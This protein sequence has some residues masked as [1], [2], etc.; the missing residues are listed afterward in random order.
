MKKL[1]ALL[2]AGTMLLAMAACGNSSAGSSQPPAA[3]PTQDAAT[4]TDPPAEPTDPPAETD[5]PAEPTDAPAAP[6]NA[7][8]APGD[9]VRDLTAFYNTMFPE[10]VASG[11]TLVPME[12]DML[13]YAYPGLAAMDLKQMVVYGPLMSAVAYEIALVEAPDAATAREVKA[14]LDSR[15]SNMQ[16]DQGN[17]PAVTEMWQTSAYAE[18]DG[19]YLMLVVG[20]NAQEEVN[21]FH[22]YIENASIREP[23]V[24][25][26]AGGE[27]V[28]NSFGG[29]EGD[30][31]EAGGGV[32]PPIFMPGGPGTPGVGG[33]VAG[34]PDEEVVPVEP[35]PEG[36]ADLEGFFDAV[37]MAHDCNLGWMDDTY[38]KEH[39]AGVV[40]LPAYQRAY[41]RPAMTGVPQEMLLVQLQN[42]EDVQTLTDTLNEYVQNMI[43]GGA[44]Y[45]STME[46]WEKNARVVSNGNYV[47]LVVHGDSDA[48]VDE[49]NALFA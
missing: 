20:E 36:S 11:L 5:A 35:A 9:D 7:P 8:E 25:D 31:P 27:D 13:E 34:D 4:P 18:E 17:Y 29:G 44:D 42:A 47:M 1:L 6:T 22:T 46:Q 32:V 49:F 45:P 3:T 41:Y 48:I 21:W 24:Y 15:I 2:L 16:N 38:L 19:N 39:I 40:S 23:A 10:A 30:D 43:N 12:G 37:S 26:P 28:D 14:L 33:S